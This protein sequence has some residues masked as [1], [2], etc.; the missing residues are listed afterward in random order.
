MISGPEKM[1]CTGSRGC[2]M[3]SVMFSFMV[4][5]NVVQSS[6]FKCTLYMVYAMELCTFREHLSKHVE[7][8]KIFR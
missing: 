3:K 5:L 6:F 1:T 4:L 8:H 7:C 2:A